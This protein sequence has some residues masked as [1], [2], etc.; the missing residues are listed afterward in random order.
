[1]K[2]IK[3]EIKNETAGRFDL[4]DNGFKIAEIAADTIDLSDDFFI[5]FIKNN[6][7]IFTVIKLFFDK[8][9]LTKFNKK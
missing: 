6:E 5:F 7:K 3:I 1:M 4:Y 9:M 2:Q 8:N